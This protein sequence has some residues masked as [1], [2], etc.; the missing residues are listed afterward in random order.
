MDCPFVVVAASGMMMVVVLGS[1]NDD[2]EADSEVASAAACIADLGH[3]TATANDNNPCTRNPFWYNN[4]GLNN[5]LFALVVQYLSCGGF[6]NC[7]R[8]VC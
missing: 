3:M 4:S 6:E 2:G 7:Q 5:V 8:I 1:T